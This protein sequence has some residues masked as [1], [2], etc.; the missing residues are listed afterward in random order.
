MT[1]RTKRD[2]PTCHKLFNSPQDHFNRA[3][4][5]TSNVRQRIQT[6]HPNSEGTMIASGL[7]DIRRRRRV[8][9][10]VFFLYLPVVALADLIFTNA[11]A[12]YVAGFW[13]A[14]F[15]ISGFRVWSSR[16]PRCGER[17]HTTNWW[18]NCWTRR[19]LHC[20]LSVNDNAR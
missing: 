7:E 15:G 16:C 6:M 19:C 4:G 18:H 1:N 13:M 12:P 9:W 11:V 2:A 10:I 17:F 20:Q 8:V 5:R 3:G 14:V